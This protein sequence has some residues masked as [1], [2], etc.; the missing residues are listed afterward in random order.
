[1]RTQIAEVVLPV[2]FFLQINAGNQAEVREGDV[3][4]NLVLNKAIPS[5]P[6]LFE[7]AI[8]SLQARDIAN[9]NKKQL[10]FTYHNQTPV[11]LIISKDDTKLRL[12]SPDFASLWYLCQSLVS[13][14]FD[15]FGKS[16]LQI[17]Y[18]DAIPL[19]ELFTVIDEHAAYRGEILRLKKVLDDRS[20]QFRTIQ[21][22]LLNRFKD[23]N[24]TP[25][26]NLDFLLNHTYMQLIEAATGS[27]QM[28]ALLGQT[29]LKLSATLD[30]TL[31]LVKL[32][33]FNS[34]ESQESFELL[35]GA[36]CVEADTIR[37]LDR[38]EN[39]WEDVANASLGYLLKN[40]LGG[41]AGGKASAAANVQTSSQIKQL[42]DV[43][44]LKQNITHV[45]DKISKGVRLD[46]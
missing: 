10:T 15:L 31:L 32:R 33:F 28:I 35:R 24:P 4:L 43:E 2:A 3:K 34:Q 36:F 14:L 16:E 29:S 40:A 7:D 6:S 37:E 22:R 45:C 17:T 46:L 18:P 20:Y 39:C 42:Q 5:L 13:R 21:K 30:L 19:N 26:N 44:K 8:E 11:T 25:L 9:Q 41:K 12:Q 23:K 1:M 27:Q 38:G